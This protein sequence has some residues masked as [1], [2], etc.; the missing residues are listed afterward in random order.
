MR[1]KEVAHLLNM[2]GLFTYVTSLNP[3]IV[4]TIP[5][6][7]RPSWW[8]GDKNSCLGFQSLSDKAGWLSKSWG[9]VIN[10]EIGM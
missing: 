9:A 1:E 5:I 3:H 6:F 7:G 8:E 2:G 4:N 10:L